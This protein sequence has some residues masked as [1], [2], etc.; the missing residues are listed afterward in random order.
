MLSHFSHVQLFVTLWTI[1][2]QAPLSM[3]IL[4]SGILEWVA[5]PSSRVSSLLRDWTQVSYVSCI[6]R[7]VLYHWHHLGSPRQL[8]RLVFIT[9]YDDGE[10]IRGSSKYLH[11]ICPYIYAEYFANKGLSSQGYG[12]SSGHVW[13]WELDCEES[14]VTKNWCFWTVVLEKTLESH[15]DC[16]EI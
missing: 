2:R 6:G 11:F 9:N 15:L 7:Q 16:R 1:A 12:F 5:M 10:G 3:K 4:Q 8:L 14:W 13:M